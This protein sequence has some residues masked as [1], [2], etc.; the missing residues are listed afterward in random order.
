MARTLYVSLLAVVLATTA[1]TAQVPKTAAPTK[2]KA[3]LK[4]APVKPGG[5]ADITA[6]V[7]TGASVLWRITPTPIQKAEGLPAG[8]LIFSGEPGTTYNASAVVIDFE[9]KTVEEVEYSVP[10]PGELI[11]PPK[12]KDPPPPPPPPMADRL[13]FL[14]VRPNGPASPAFTQ[15]MSDPAWTA[16]T[17]AGHTYKDKTLTEAAALR[18]VLPPGTVLPVVVTLRVSADGTNSELVRGPIPLPTTAEAIRLLP[19]V[20]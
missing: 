8:R 20:K 12:K 5:F 6:P 18:V 9:K 7:P 1:A 15:T 11:P 16:L 2:A 10:F 13:Y 3:V 17:A 4:A 19:E 14:I